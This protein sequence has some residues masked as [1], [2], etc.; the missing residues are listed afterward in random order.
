MDNNG[1]SQLAAFRP[2]WVE[3]GVIYGNA[4]AIRVGIGEPKAFIDLETLGSILEILFKLGYCALGPGTAVDSIEIEI[5]ENGEATRVAFG[6]VA[7]HR[8]ELI[9]APSAQIDHDAHV[10]GVHFFD[11]IGEIGWSMRH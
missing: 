11:A 7:S 5:G 6:H 2:D 9:T 4:F 8:F 1:Y 3:T 10:H